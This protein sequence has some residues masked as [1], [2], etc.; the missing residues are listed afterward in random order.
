[1][2]ALLAILV[3]VASPGTGLVAGPGPTARGPGT[4]PAPPAAAAKDA[5]TELKRWSRRLARS[6]GPLS[7]SQARELDQVLAEVTGALSRDPG[8]EREATLA[9]LE[10]VVA[11]EDLARRAAFGPGTEP[12]RPLERARV[13]LRA[14][15][16]G[17]GGPDTARW[18]ADSVL[19]NTKS[20]SAEIRR[21]AAA[22]L[23]E[24]RH[25]DALPALILTAGDED[26]FVAEAAR[27]ALV[28]WDDPRVH[29]VFLDLLEEREALREVAAHLNDPEAK[30]GPQALERLRGIVGRLYVSEDWRD[31]ARAR[32]VVAALDTMRAAPILIEALAVWSRRGE[33]GDGSRRILE[34][35][36]IELRRLSGR[37]LGRDPALWNRWWGD[38]LRG[39]TLLPE[40]ALARGE[41]MTT[42]TFFGLRLTSDRVLF[43]V[44][45]SGSMDSRFGSDDDHSRYEE[46]VEQLFRFLEQSGETTRFGVALF[47]DDADPW[48]AGKLLEATA[49]A[50]KQAR[51]WLSGKRPK[52][53]TALR[54][55]LFE[56]LGGDRSGRVQAAR[57]EADTVVVLCDGATAEGPAWVERWVDRVGEDLQLMI[58]GV[59]IGSHGDGTLEALAAAT[60]GQFVR[61]ER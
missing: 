28:G 16:K 53:G 15:L 45:R 18:L 48:R 41:P 55:G 33:A 52:G 3:L 40:A 9:L 47:H 26:A 42:A 12:E 4:A 19:R 49:S 25:A 56:A 54:A 23:G 36:V 14:R 61:I 6:R 50:Q 46:A 7:A 37:N 39:E 8:R 21:V 20:H 34:E 29:L 10:L 1:M 24:S 32:Q 51:R 30:P 35:I 59:Q 58:H 60:G 31:A 27:V 2:R 17:V 38:V 43:V 57:V 11:A 5:I 44:D 13:A 22:A